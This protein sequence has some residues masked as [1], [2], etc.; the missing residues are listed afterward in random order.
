MLVEL[1]MSQMWFNHCVLELSEP[2]PVRKDGPTI[3]EE[4]FIDYLTGS[5]QQTPTPIVH[6]SL[7]QISTRQ[8]LLLCRRFLPFARKHC[9]R[10][11][12]L[13]EY[14]EPCRGY[15][16]DCKNYIPRRNPVHDLSRAYQQNVLYGNRGYPFQFVP[17]Y[18]KK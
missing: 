5:T 8:L 18:Y 4:L 12:T 7:A 16:Q 10:E 9:R 15:F 11:F 17:D 1:S 13:I 3:M 2:P 14:V 6:D